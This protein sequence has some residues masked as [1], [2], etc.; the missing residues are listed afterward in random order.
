MREVMRIDVVMPTYNSNKGIF[1]L[2]LE[3][4][5]RYVPLNRLIVVDRYSNDGTVELIREKFPD[6]LVIQTSASLGYARH[7]GIRFVETEWFAFIDSDVI[8][9][10]TWFNVVSKYTK[11]DK[12]GA[13]ESSYVNINFLTAKQ[14]LDLNDAVR[15]NRAVRRLSLEEL[16]ANTV[17]KHG[18]IHARSSLDIAL[19][20]KDS[21]KDWVPNP[22]L[23]AYEDLAITQHVIRKGYYWLFIDAPLALHG[24]PPRSNL[25]KLRASI[26]KGLWEGA[27][28]KYAGIPRDFIAL[29]AVTRLLGAV[30]RLIKH[31]DPF[32]L[33]M[34]IAFLLSLP[35]NR[36]LVVRR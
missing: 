16:S 20:R 34:R 6:A 17:I 23:N 1:S 12:V 8:V 3:S 26:R 28:I 10:P 33:A 13:I 14:S 2:V 32:N 22:Y 24:N 18:F 9:L 15:I 19:V 25:D 35:S 29:Y 11:Y 31:N 4:I 36:Y 30:Y 27:G 7:I 5:R 21:V